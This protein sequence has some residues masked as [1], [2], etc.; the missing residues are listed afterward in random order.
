MGASRWFDWF[1]LGFLVA[2]A[3]AAL[4]ATVAHAQTTSDAEQR[5]ELRLRS[6]D[7]ERYDSRP[8]P[9][10]RAES[11]G[12]DG[13]LASSERPL[14]PDAGSASTSD[15]TGEAATDS[16]EGAEDREDAGDEQ[17]LVRPLSTARTD[18]TQGSAAEGVNAQEGVLADRE[19]EPLIDGGDPT[20]D[21]RSL[22]D[23]AVFEEPPAGHDPLL[24][25]VEDLDPVETDRRPER[26]ARLDPFEPI[27]VRIGGFVL[28]PEA[29]LSGLA[30][31]NVLSSP[32]PVA[33]RALE[34]RTNTRLVSNWTR[35]ALELR[36]STASSFYDETPT[37][38]EEA[39]TLEA[40]GR[41]DI[42]RRA[43]FQAIATHDV[44]QQS[45]LGVNAN[46]SSAPADIT[47]N[48]LAVAYTQQFNRLTLQLRGSVSGIDYADT[49]TVINDELDRTTGNEALRLSW[50]FKPTLSAFVEGGASQLDTAAV[51]ASD[52]RS[53]DA[54]G[55][56]WRVGLDFG[57]TSPILRGEIS[58]GY[59]RQ[60]PEDNTLAVTDA[61]L[62]DSNLA[63]RATDLTSVMLVARTDIADSSEANTSGA[64]TR[65]VGI[66]V[67]HALRRY[68]VAS[69]G[70][71]YS[72]F[73]FTTSQVRENATVASLGVEYFASPE[74]VIFGRYEHLDFNSNEANSDYE[75][76]AVRGG[77]RLRR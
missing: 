51:A 23:R 45:R 31:S 13:S 30:T 55:S 19:P 16:G 26:L 3:V 21:T 12:S 33:D 69:A 2:T 34:L 6:L 63:W 73:A 25:Q 27:G 47:T 15:E 37:E 53:R 11:D 58:V 70:L 35:H 54:T 28:F 17:R 40:R 32:S 38:N 77:L 14:T 43:N 59:G 67:R 74:V 42:T 61:F 22:D 48:T 72:D 7:L 36:G 66:E 71:S 41:L 18:D 68:V 52:G 29:E 5:R 20:Q 50:Q 44:A 24:F 1:F 64:V 46:T 9:T 57:G 8:A 60:T 10:R 49:D 62:F 4:N 65:Q 75:V 39:Y 56:S 76:D